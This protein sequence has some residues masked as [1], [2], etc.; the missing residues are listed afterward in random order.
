VSVDRYQGF[1]FNPADLSEDVDLD[2]ERRKEILFADAHLARWTHWE[3]L[4]LPWSAPAADARA[5]YLA[6][7]KVF[8]PD[9]YAGKRLGSYR[10][11]LERAFRK[12]TE[13]RDVLGD[14]SRRAAYVKASAPPEEFA[15]LEARK[16]DDERRG[17]ERRARLARQNPILARAA[18]VT[19]LVRRGK[20]ALAEGRFGAAANDL[21]LAQGLDPQN[22]EIAALAAD[23]RRKAGAAR[24]AELFRKG[25]EA[26]ALGN[27]AAA[28]ASF[29]E[30]LEADPSHVRAAAQGARAAAQLGNLARARSLA[31]AALEASPRSGA[32]HEALGLVLELEGN[33]KDARKAYERAL[34]L[35]PKL[36]AAKERLKR[37]RWGFLG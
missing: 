10:A 36:D 21:L 33:K 4:G 18:R 16:L 7:V 13:A 8:H 2:L 35:D 6:K 37:L 34:E 27:P 20:G 23:A 19:D 5:A 11:R 31:D 15:R 22:G 3:V 25:L 30:A 28:L 9:R 17:E 32:A 1:V 24:A 14:E 29:G 26:E 12:I